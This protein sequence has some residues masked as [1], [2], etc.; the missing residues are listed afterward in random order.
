MKPVSLLLSGGC[1]LFIAALCVLA[2]AKGEEMPVTKMQTLEQEVESLRVRVEALEMRL[3]ESQT[4]TPKKLQAQHDGLSGG[5][6]CPDTGGLSNKVDQL[7]LDLTANCI[8]G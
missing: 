4:A 3:E 1:L 5:R 6:Q 2:L 7:A 8:G